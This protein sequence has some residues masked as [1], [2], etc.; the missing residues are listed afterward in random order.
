VDLSTRQ[1]KIL[2][3]NS[4]EKSGLRGK[5]NLTVI[6]IRNI[7][8]GNSKKENRRHKRADNNLGDHSI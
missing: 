8:E 1:L 3:E 6:C 4:G 5:K 2:E 7:K